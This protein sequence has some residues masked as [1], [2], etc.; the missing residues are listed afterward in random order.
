MRAYFRQ[1][2][3]L[4]FAYGLAS[5]RKPL[6]DSQVDAVVI[7]PASSAFSDTDKLLPADI[8]KLISSLEDGPDAQKI[9]ITS[10]ATANAPEPEFLPGVTPS[11][12]LDA[13]GYGRSKMIANSRWC[14]I[15]YIGP[16]TGTAS[17]PAGAGQTGKPQNDAQVAA[18][19]KENDSIPVVTA[20]W[21]VTK[22]MDEY[23]APLLNKIPNG[24]NILGAFKIQGAYFAP[25]YTSQSGSRERDNAFLVGLQSLYLWPSS[26]FEISQRPDCKPPYMST[27]HDPTVVGHEVAHAIFNHLRGAKSLDGF[28]W[29]AV[30][31]GYADYFSAA[32][33]ST[34]RIGRIW[35]IA[36]TTQQHLRS[37]NGSPTT[38]S[39]NIVNEAHQFSTVWSSALWRLRNRLISEQ[40]AV[41][42]EVDAMVLLS[43]TYLGETERIRMGDAA[44]SL[45]KASESSNK[46]AW[47]K[48]IREEMN[49]AEIELAS[50]S[51]LSF[52]PGDATSTE[53][54]SA[55]SSGACGT[56][57]TQNRLGVGMFFALLPALFLALQ[58][59]LSLRRKS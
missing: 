48:I 12:D 41:P 58:G 37:I 4:C 46:T 45:L 39:P 14:T 8:A 35:K 34:P 36:S 38:E 31:E 19:G 27:G 28:Q 43:I 26:C 6:S 13:L 25:G 59:A 17:T 54:G 44:I 2:A 1:I 40:K 51:T 53:A 22:I 57:A 23:F 24:Q 7:K 49:N 11:S 29:T 52:L 3:I 5:C 47:N 50:G 55:K 33:Y 21:A 42:T 20:A 56:V 15:R 10:S 30:N 32:Y 16:T 9:Q 18:L